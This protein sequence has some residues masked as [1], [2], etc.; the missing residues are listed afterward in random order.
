MVEPD[1]WPFANPPN[2]ATITTRAIIDGNDWIALVSHDAD[3]GAWQFLPA[4]GYDEA[5]AMVVGLH[6]L[7]EKDGSVAELANLPLGWHAWRDSPTAP[8]QRAPH[9]D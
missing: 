4:E 8:W 1:K 3:D 5:T 7:L 6:H 9:G 2:F